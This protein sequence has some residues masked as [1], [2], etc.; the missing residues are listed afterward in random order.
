ME[1]IGSLKKNDLTEKQNG[2]IQYDIEST[3]TTELT[4]ASETTS[5]LS[6]HLPPNQHLTLLT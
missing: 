5:V 6:Q 2:L 1:R 4:S 3:S